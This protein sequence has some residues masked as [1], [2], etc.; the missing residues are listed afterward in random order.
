M[1]TAVIIMVRR[2]KSHA[3][4]N[5]HFPLDVGESDAPIPLPNV[6]AKILKKVYPSFP[7]INL[8]LK[9]TDGSCI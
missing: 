1:A 7:H 4:Y 8:L 6:T 5:D 9:T 3:N 2:V